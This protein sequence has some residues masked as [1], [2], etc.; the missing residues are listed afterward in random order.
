MPAPTL[1]QPSVATTFGCH[2]T[3]VV[4][5]VTEEQVIWS[6]ASRCVT[7]VQNEQVGIKRPVVQ[8]VGQTVRQH[9]AILAP[10]CTET[11]ITI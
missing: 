10:L 4:V 6:D 9:L 11:A 7:R 8:F 2:V 1:R 5:L 3:H